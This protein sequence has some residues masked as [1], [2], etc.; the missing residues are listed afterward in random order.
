MAEI[1]LKCPYCG[2]VFPRQ[3]RARCPSCGQ[4]VLIPLALRAGGEQTE[5]ARLARWARQ[6]RRER[7]TEQRRS[8]PFFSSRR[9]RIILAI[10]ALLVFGVLLPIRYA[11]RDAARTPAESRDER[12]VKNLWVLRTALECFRSDC[13]R[14]PS[15]AEGLKALVF[16]RHVAGWRGPYIDM[17]K[18]DPWRNDYGYSLT[19]DEVRLFSAGPDGLPGTPDDIAAPL[20]DWTLVKLRN[21]NDAPAEPSAPRTEYPIEIKP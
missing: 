19:G 9:S 7:L 20:P 2:H 18:W 12:A 3:D 14:F 13:G 21:T 8:A 17:L 11:S 10:S 1:K 6:R 15:T 4:P 16:P 5:R